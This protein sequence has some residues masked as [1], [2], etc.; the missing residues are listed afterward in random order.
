MNMMTKVVVMLP[1]PFDPPLFFL[2]VG[3]RV[4][5]VKSSVST[6]SKMSLSAAALSVASNSAG[7]TAAS[8][9]IMA[10]LIDVDASIVYN[11]STE[12]CCN[13]RRLRE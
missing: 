12:D 9:A 6:V 13:S 1:R 2:L 10:S 4:G 11:T 7:V 3:V 5:A 8:A